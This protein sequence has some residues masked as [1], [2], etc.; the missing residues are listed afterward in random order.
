MKD[1]RIQTSVVKAISYRIL[2]NPMD[3]SPV[4]LVAKI[5]FGNKSNTE[6][7]KGK[8]YSEALESIVKDMGLM[9]PLDDKDDSFIVSIMEMD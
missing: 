8:Y 3:A 2:C 6:L 9:S 5:I 7:Y 1:E 4:Y